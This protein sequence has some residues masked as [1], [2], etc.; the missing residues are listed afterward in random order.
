MNC[1]NE[2]RSG[3]GNPDLHSDAADDPGQMSSR[4]TRTSHVRSH[5]AA[6]ARRLRELDGYEEVAT[7][8]DALVPET[9]AEVDFERLDEQLIALEQRM[10]ALAESR[11]SFDESSQ[12]L[13]DANANLAGRRAKMTGAQTEN[14][15]R[16][17]YTKLLFE[18]R[19]LPRLIVFYMV[20]DL[21]QVA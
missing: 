17:F 12:I 4:P 3:R 21:R 5:L 20:D 8:L 6:C 16:Q 2:N 11:L 1:E 15:R 7:A 9:N 14:L 10:A 13:N 18:R 19:G